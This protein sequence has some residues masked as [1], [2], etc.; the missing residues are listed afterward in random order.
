LSL[1]GGLEIEKLPI[2]GH[3]RTHTYGRASASAPSKN[4]HT[5]NIVSQP[6]GCDA[7]PERGN[8]HERRTMTKTEPTTEHLTKKYRKYGTFGLI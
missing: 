1:P 2:Q 5:Y 6:Q 8:V 3:A 7:G 4:R